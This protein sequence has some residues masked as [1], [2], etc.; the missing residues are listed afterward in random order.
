MELADLMTGNQPTAEDKMKMA[1]TYQKKI[2]DFEGMANTYHDVMQPF[3]AYT[4]LVQEHDK[5]FLF[6]RNSLQVSI[7]EIL[8]QDEDL[9]NKCDLAYKQEKTRRVEMTKHWGTAPMRDFQGEQRAR[10]K[11][12]DERAVKVQLEALRQ[13]KAEQVIQPQ[14]EAVGD[15]G[16]VASLIPAQK[17]LQK[18]TKVLQDWLVTQKEYKPGEVFVLPKG[19]KH[20]NIQTTLN[21]E[22]TDKKLFDLTIDSFIRHFWQKQKIAAL[23]R[24]R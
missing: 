7:C 1:N 20:K 17:D 16:A 13:F 5:L 22:S 18:R 14:T 12:A 19:I 21:N 2:K 24:G 8:R 6:S 10:E 11:R 3:S 9:R 15:A 23:K 4:A